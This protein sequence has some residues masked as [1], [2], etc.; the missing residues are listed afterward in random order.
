MNTATTDEAI[1]NATHNMLEPPRP[2]SFAFAKRYGVM[3]RALEDD[4][5]EDRVPQRCRARGDRGS[6]ATPRPPA[7]PGEGRS[8]ALRPAAAAVLRG[9]VERRDGRDGRLRGRRRPRQPRAGHPR[10]VRPARERGRGAGHPPDQRAAHPGGQGKRLGHPHRALREPARDPVPRRRRA[11]RGAAD[12]AR[13]RPADRLAR[14]GDVAARHRREAPAAGRPHLAA[15]R[16]PRGR[17]ARLDDP[18]RARRA[19]RAATARQ[20]GRQARPAVARHGPADR[21]VAR[22]PDPQ[23]ERDHPGHRTDRLRQDH[24]AVRRARPDQR[25]HAQHHDGRGP[26]RVLHRRHRPDPGQHAR[27][28]DLRAWPARDPAPGPRRGDGRRNPRPRD[29]ADRRAGLLD[30][31]PRALDAAHEHRGRRRHAPARH[32]RR[33]LP[34]VLEHPRRARAAPRARAEP[35][36]RASP[37]SPASTSVD[38]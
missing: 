29:R 32:G 17:R 26:D 15:H 6:A 13:G 14:Q 31:P 8:R 12:Q 25:P 16:R 10:A 11:A 21:G 2:L 37:T 36:A 24:H 35:G 4:R 19:R 28:H 22:R 33:A 3:L 23:A 5:A 1:V 20:A 34:A 9:R 7:A 27:R 38:C 18:G 30:R